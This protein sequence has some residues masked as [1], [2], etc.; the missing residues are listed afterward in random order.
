[1]TKPEEM[2]YKIR[3]EVQSMEEIKHRMRGQG[4]LSVIYGESINS[5]HNLILV[6]ESM[7]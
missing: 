2:G 6:G 1:M 7:E 3:K 4:Q 5:H